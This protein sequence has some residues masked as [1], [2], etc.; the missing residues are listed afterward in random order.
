MLSLLPFGQ[1]AVIQSLSYNQIIEKVIDFSSAKSELA[2]K[3]EAETKVGSSE[4]SREGKESAEG[5]GS[6]E[7]CV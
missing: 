5:K 4:E 2:A 1:Y 6:E 7:G 3:A